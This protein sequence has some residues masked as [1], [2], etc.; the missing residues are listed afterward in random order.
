MGDYSLD[1]LKEWNDRIEEVA[2][3]F[4]LDYYPQEYEI[5]DYEDMIAY[6]TYLGMP[7][8]YPHWSF[9]KNYERTKTF[10]K[11]NI[12]GLPY[13][14]VINSDPCIAYLMKEN[15]LLLQVLT[16]AH[17]YGHNDFFKNNRLFKD[18][19]D[20]NY[21]VEMFKNHATRVRK[22]IQDME[23]G[24][25]EVEKI[26]DAAHGIKLQ[27]NRIMRNRKKKEDEGLYPEENLLLFIRDHGNL[28]GWQQDLL[29]IVMEETK[30]FIPQIE[31]KIMNEGWASFWHYRILNELNLPQEMHLEFIG[32]HNM[33]L[34]PHLGNINPY[35]LG[36]HVFKDIEKKYGLK[37]IF[38]V[39][40]LERDASFIRRYV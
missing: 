27:T 38:E 17:V 35:H 8:Q 22:Y 15:T 25:E 12:V 23:I 9:G 30:Y 13:E 4:G 39:R 26:L 34:R 10:Y 1:Q 28:K 32:R 5:V 16:M 11:Y 6:E 3:K 7:S 18:D 21:T 2:Q 37:K 33:V 19:T 14:M 20:A 36:F 29:T 31:T 40:E 24:Y